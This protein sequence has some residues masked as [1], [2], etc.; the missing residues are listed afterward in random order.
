M[1]KRTEIVQTSFVMARG[2]HGGCET[3][4]EVSSSTAESMIAVKE[5]T[6]CTHESIT[7]SD[8]LTEGL[9]QTRRCLPP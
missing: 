7:Q 4:W 8:V 1:S 6:R 3:G 9:R 5:E 2:Q